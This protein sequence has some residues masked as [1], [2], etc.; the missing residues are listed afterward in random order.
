M[1]RLY[2]SLEKLMDEYGL[3]LT[4]EVSKASLIFDVQGVSIIRQ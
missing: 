1:S 2:P 3:K 4:D